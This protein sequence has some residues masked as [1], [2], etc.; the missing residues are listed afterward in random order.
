M[1]I[2]HTPRLRLVIFSL[3]LFAVQ[4]FWGFFAATLPLFLMERARSE[5]VTGLILALAGIFGMSLP[6]LCGAASDR[7]RGKWR[8]RVF[9]AGGWAAVIVVL[10]ILP[11]AHSLGAVV[12]LAALLYAAF[13]T[14]MGPYFALLADIT[15]PGERGSAAGIMFLVGGTGN[16]LYLLVGARLGEV[17]PWGS[18]LFTAAC[19]AAGAGTMIAGTR[20]PLAP[21]VRRDGHTLLRYVMSRKDLLFFYGALFLWW[22]GNWMANTFF[23][24]AVKRLFNVPTGTAVTGLFVVTLSFVLFAFPMGR[25]GDRL[26]HR[27]VTAAGLLLLALIYMVIPH[28]HGMT[29][30]FIA[31]IGAGAGFSVLL[32]VAYAFF[33]SL[34]PP[35]RTAALLG[36]YMACQNGSLLVG[37]ALGGVLLEHWGPVALFT[38]AGL[39]LLGALAVLSRVPVIRR[40]GEIPGFTREET[41]AD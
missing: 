23:V 1:T 24:L 17:H 4:T 22:S 21:P 11:M 41:A 10:L 39:I 9:I 33:T 36:I 35:E 32:S 30:A 27:R 5:T 37:N 7:L 25:L 16:L 2:A 40:A 12:V 15:S 28:I 29:A 18:F 6:V 13:F 20:E 3:G 19:I 38:G 34:I 8:R 26:G 14:T 31:L